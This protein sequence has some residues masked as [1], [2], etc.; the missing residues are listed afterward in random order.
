MTTDFFWRFLVPR[1]YKIQ[2][3]VHVERKSVVLLSGRLEA[4]GV[5]SAWGEVSQESPKNR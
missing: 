4:S 5:K 2:T 1:N 3:V